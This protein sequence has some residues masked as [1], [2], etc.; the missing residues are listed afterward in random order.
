MSLIPFMFN[1][2]ALQVVII[3]GKK[4]WR[5]KEVCKALKY[6]EKTAHII[7]A[8][9]STENFTQKYQLSRFP[10]AG[11]SVN[12]PIDLQKYDFYINEEGL[13]DLVLTS[14]QPQAAFLAE[15]LC[16]NVH[17]HKY[18]SKKNDSIEIIMGTFDGK[19]MIRQFHIGKYY[20]D[21]Y[22]PEHKLAIECDEFGHNNHDVLY[23][24]NRQK[25][26]EDQ[27][28][29]QFFRYNPDA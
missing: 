15:K 9:C 8:H 22:F 26:I 16:L 27:L 19:E 17:K 25:F 23:K 3:N 20:I 5:T 28:Q 10:A 6:R 18:M 12:W 11:N 24:V 2:V 4:W 1:N 13:R 14:Q 29:C 7:R 21:L